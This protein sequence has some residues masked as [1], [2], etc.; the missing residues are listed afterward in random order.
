MEKR[1]RFVLARLVEQKEEAV[2]AERE[3]A[4]V[5]EP[6]QKGVNGFRSNGVTLDDE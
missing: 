4:E 3:S 2:Q 5:S 1:N 6:G